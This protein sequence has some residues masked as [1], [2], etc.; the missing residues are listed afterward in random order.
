MNPKKNIRCPFKEN[1][2]PK[3]RRSM[4]DLIRQLACFSFSEVARSTLLWSEAG[5]DSRNQVS[6][7]FDSRSISV[8][9][10]AL[11]RTTSVISANFHER[12][13]WGWECAL[14]YCLSTLQ[15]IALMFHFPRHR[16]SMK[17]SELSAHRS[18][19]QRRINWAPSQTTQLPTIF[20]RSTCWT[21]SDVKSPLMIAVTENI[22]REMYCLSKH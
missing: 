22:S 5:W 19:E 13:L 20:L 18:N 11:R 10:N 4:S 12:T 21:L 15:E 6:D 9:I 8:L 7:S 1:Q 3:V 14:C 16:I 17:N 2:Y